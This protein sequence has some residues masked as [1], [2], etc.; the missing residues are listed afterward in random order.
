MFVPRLVSRLVPRL[1]P[2][3]VSMFVSMFV[4]M[5]VPR[6]VPMFVPMLVPMLVPM[7]VSMFVLVSMSMFV[8]TGFALEVHVE[9]HSLDRRLVL[10]GHMEVIPTQAELAEFS[11]E[12]SKFHA[13]VEH[14]TNE[15][16][17]TDSAEDVQIQAAHGSNRLS[18][19]P[20]RIRQ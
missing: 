1:V 6:L 8:P 3:F 2:M 4:P 18:V 14:G 19:G 9:L 5:F 11:F 10:P 17:T 20:N 13:E 7:F 16:V 12:V 15:H